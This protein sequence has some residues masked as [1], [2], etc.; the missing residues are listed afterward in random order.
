[1]TRYL[2]DFS[3]VVD[4]LNEIAGHDDLGHDDAFE[5]LA[6]GYEDHRP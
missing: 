3:F 2:L 6:A 5:R 4:L 1:M